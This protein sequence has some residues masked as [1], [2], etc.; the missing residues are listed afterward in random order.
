MSNSLRPYGLWLARL[1]WSWNSP[2]K[3]TGVGCHFLLQGIFL[4]QESNTG[5]LHYRQILYQL[6]YEGSP[7][8]LPIRTCYLLVMG[9]EK[10][11][12]RA[13]WLFLCKKP[14]PP[15]TCQSKW[16]EGWKP[17]SPSFHTHLHLPSFSVMILVAL[18]PSLN[19]LQLFVVMH[20]SGLLHVS[21]RMSHGA[22]FG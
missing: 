11:A 16:C 13:G 2:G 19:N 17:C 20:F 6:S 4:T 12:M 5:L 7:D 21:P 1:L 8:L 10:E 3:H 14:T 22:L 15:W 9:S 18:S